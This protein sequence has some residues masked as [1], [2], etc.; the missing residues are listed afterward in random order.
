MS[1]TPPSP[2]AAAPAHNR[3]TGLDIAALIF[4]IL[5]P[6][7]GLI[8]ALVGRSSAKN[9]GGPSSGV[10]TA[11]L[12][13]SIV[14]TGLGLL[15]FVAFIVIAI[16]GFGLTLW[17]VQTYSEPTHPSAANEVTLSVSA[18]ATTLDAQTM[19]AT[20]RLIESRLDRAGILYDDV[21]ISGVNLQLAMPANAQPDDVVLAGEIAAGRYYA[22]VR[23]VLDSAE[24]PREAPFTPH[25]DPAERLV[26]CDG[27]GVELLTL[28]PAA[29]SGSWA[30]DAHATELSTGGQW[31]VT[32]T[33]TAEGTAAMADL[34]SRL[35]DEGPIR[36]RF[37]IV[38]DGELLTAP[39]VNAVVTSGE[40]QI[41]GGFDERMAGQLASA[42]RL[43]SA[44]LTVAVDSLTLSR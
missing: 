13:V 2:Y 33:L 4:A 26:L 43:A 11:A 37:A 20:A 8:L 22:D 29:L 30:S 32:L 34:T 19:D 5:V 14:L 17:A 18:D 16:F 21:Y 25:I 6:P 10:L 7:V 42:I 35:I 44:G 12:V 39:L 27:D 9:E 40:L 15:M 3:V 38:V 1:A 23:P 31:V 24:C 41:A 36:G 28:A